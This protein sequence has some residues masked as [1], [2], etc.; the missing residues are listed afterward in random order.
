MAIRRAAQVQVAEMQDR[1]PIEAGGKRGSCSVR[2]TISTL[3]I[4]LP[5][6]WATSDT[7]PRPSGT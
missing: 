1:E 7:L 2:S 6:S 4:S 5:G 3:Q